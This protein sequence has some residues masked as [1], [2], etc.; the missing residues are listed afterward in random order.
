MIIQFILLILFGFYQNGLEGREV[1]AK[2]EEFYTQ[3]SNATNREDS[4]FKLEIQA[5]ENS[6]KIVAPAHSNFVLPDSSTKAIPYKLGD[7]NAD[8]K[9]DMLLNLG[10]C[11]TGGCIYG[12]FLNQYGNNYTLA[13]MDYLKNI[14]F[15]V[16][17]SG[18]WAIVSSEEVDPY[19]PYKSQVSIFTFDAYKYAY[20][21]DTT[22][23]HVDQV[24]R[25]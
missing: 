12:L 22:Y 17:N 1:A 4:L 9:E 8:K 20:E 7:F 19:N 25:E 6:V 14:E 15:R 23:L 18:C 24:D 16:E 13:F 10:A 3:S 2:S 21:L 5:N 11:G